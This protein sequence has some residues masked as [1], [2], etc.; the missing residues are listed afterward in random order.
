MLECATRIEIEHNIGFSGFFGVYR[1]RLV[2]LH[3]YESADCGSTGFISTT[4]VPSISS[5]GLAFI[6]SPVIL[7]TLAHKQVRSS[8]FLYETLWL[9]SR[10]ICVYIIHQMLLRL[11]S[12]I[13]ALATTP[14]SKKTI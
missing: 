1:K 3:H 11:R 5:K 6:L 12:T 8:L 7:K 14:A 10:Y 4:S 9:T 13:I 2:K